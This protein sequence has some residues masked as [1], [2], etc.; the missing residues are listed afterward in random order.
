MN[1]PTPNGT[2]LV[3]IDGSRNSLLAA[4]V[5][6]RM[7]AVL[8][9][10]L[11]LIHI[12]DVPPLSFWVGVESRM[13][14]DIRAQAEARLTDTAAR[15]TEACGV[16]PEFY[17]V[18]GVPEEE[19]QRAVKGDPEIL[20]VVLGSHGVA[21]EKKAELRLHRRMG[22]LGAK[23]T[24]AL[25]VPVMLV[26]PDVPSSQICSGLEEFVGAGAETTAG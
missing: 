6:A 1:K 16:I 22:R 15:I 24:E 25:P 5:A 19:I 7:A 13:K 9:T 11:G 26:P 21:T 2:I 8:N 18:E 3:A 14:E 4:G 12:L 10:H 20:M 23:L 17:I